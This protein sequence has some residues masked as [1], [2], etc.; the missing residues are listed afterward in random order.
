[1]SNDRYDL[2][3]KNGRIIDGTGSPAYIGDIAVKGRRIVKI[4]PHICETSDTMIDAEGL[5]VCPG[6][7]DSHCHTDIAY[8]TEFPGVPGKVMQGVTTD[9]CGLCSTSAAPVGEGH[10]NEFLSREANT[11]GGVRKALSYRDFIKETEERG[12]ST[13]M[14]MFVGNANLR[15]HAVGYENKAADQYQMD[16]MKKLLRQSME[17]GAFGLSTGLTYV[18]SE[19][20]STEELIELCRVAAEYGGMYN[21]HMRNEGKGVFKSIEEVIEIAEKGGCRGHCS[22]LKIADASCHGQ[23]DK[24]LKLIEDANKRGDRIT[25]DVYAYTAGSIMLS[26]MLPSWILSKGFGKDFSILKN[27]DI[28]AKI[29]E[30]MKKD[31][32]E[33]IVLQCGYENIYVGYANGLPQYKGKSISEIA[34][35]EGISNLEAVLKVLIKSN[36]QATVV[37]YMISEED[38]KTFIRSPYCL[39]GTDAF[40]RDYEGITTGGNPHPRNFNG[41]PRFIKKYVLDEKLISLEEGIRRLTGLPAEIFRIKDRGLIKE[42]YVADL[43]II[44]PEIIRDTGTYDLP[45]RKPQGIEYVLIGGKFAVNRGEFIDIRAGRALTMGEK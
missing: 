41:I 18:P 20:A 34:E 37:Y 44:D 5:C 45:A 21:S 23:A 12:N 36:A 15:I 19:F 33:N 17:E 43:T 10:L 27:P 26:A 28:V 31:D 13:N 4:S 16:E 11:P 7:F 22:H 24:C 6:F 2:V 3:I 32:W 40:A 29:K 8:A 39:I 14:A 42:G 30:D 25:F 35:E 38:L 9:V 1:L